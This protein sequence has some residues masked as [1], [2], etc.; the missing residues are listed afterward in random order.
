MCE[1]HW[2]IMQLA[3]HDLT[4]KLIKNFQYILLPLINCFFMI[5]LKCVTLQLFDANDITNATLVT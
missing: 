1:H 3:L 2:N 5:K 4:Y